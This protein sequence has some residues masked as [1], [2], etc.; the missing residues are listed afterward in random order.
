MRRAFVLLAL[1]LV[2]VA[3]GRDSATAPS[4][5]S[6]SAALTP[7]MPTGEWPATTIEAADLDPARLGDL[8]LRIRRGDYG[9]I[10]SVLIARHGRLAVEEYFNGWSAQ[11][12]HTM[13]SVTKSVVSLLAGVA[14]GSGRLSSTDSATAFFPAYQ[15]IANMDDRKTAMTVRDLLTMRTGFDWTEDPYAGSP[16]QRLNDCGCDWLRFI[17]DWRMREPPG[18]RW[19]YVSGGVI[20]L[21][22]VIG[23]ATGSRLDRFANSVLFD[24]IGASNV[25]WA[26]GLPD[27]LPHAGGGLNLRPRDAAKIGQIV[28]DDGRWQ[29]RP[30]VDARWIQESVAPTARGLRVWGG[31]AF[32]Y[33]YLW[34]LT[35]DGGADIVAASGALGQWIFV[36]RRHD[37]VVVSTADNDDARATA[38]VDFLFQYVLPA[39]RG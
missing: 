37:L 39:V 20:L 22:G 30:I 4:P 28:L 3:C 31:H 33:G 21:G 18:S 23:A 24:P 16:L 6:L 13:Q 7:V 11:Q 25:S 10:G 36:S 26:Q 9:R 32:D 34:W 27:G 1:A 14:I 29:G 38:A 12:P 2:P 5:G 15:P 35:S 8:M 17:L 19:E